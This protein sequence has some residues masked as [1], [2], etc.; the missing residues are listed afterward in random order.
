MHKHAI[1]ATH[2][3][4]N[5]LPGINIHNPLSITA[6]NSHSIGKF[7]FRSVSRSHEAS[8]FC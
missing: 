1:H 4:A 3:S 8:S 6:T 2:V 7:I 5:P